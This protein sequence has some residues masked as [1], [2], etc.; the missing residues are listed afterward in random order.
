MKASP[1]QKGKQAKEQEPE[2]NGN[3]KNDLLLEDGEVLNQET[4]QNE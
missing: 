1:Q 4:E 3:D 2:N